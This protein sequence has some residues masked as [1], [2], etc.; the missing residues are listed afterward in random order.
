MD[1]LCVEEALRG[2]FMIQGQR[3]TL[4][5]RWLRGLRVL[6]PGEQADAQRAEKLGGPIYVSHTANGSRGQATVARR[7]I[8]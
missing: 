2:A 3:E 4:A 5:R 7:E 8:G 1:S 6:R